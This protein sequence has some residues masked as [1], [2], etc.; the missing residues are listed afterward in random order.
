MV[1]YYFYKSIK[2]NEIKYW[3][4][5]G[6]LSGASF[7]GKYQVVILFAFM[8]L[9]LLIYDIKLLKQKRVY[10]AIL[11]GLLMILPHMIWLYKTDFFSLL[12][13]V[14]R[15][16]STLSEDDKF[17][18]FKRLMFSVK[19]YLD[20]LFSLAPTFALY[21]ILALKEK[22]ITFNGSI[23]ENLK[24]KLFLIIVGLMPVL[25]IGLSGIFTASRVV[26]AWAVSM[27]C[28]V[29]ILLF[30][31]FPIKFQ[32]K[33][34]IFFM[35]WIYGMMICW[36]IAMIIFFMLQTKKDFSYPYK[37]VM[38]DFNQIWYEKTE[39]APLKYV[40]GDYAISSHIYNKQKPV[41]ILDTYNHKNPWVNG[42]DILK[43]GVLILSSDENALPYLSD[44]FKNEYNIKNIS[45]IGEYSYT[46]SNIIGK[47]R[48]YNV[49]YAIIKPEKI[50]N[51]L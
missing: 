1:I 34:Y 22:N 44:K 30:Y 35:K 9:Y 5:F 14:N 4:I 29:G 16:A 3:L 43:S 47:S 48:T 12:Y 32:E 45:D 49:Y 42:D 31:F 10:G 2:F 7:L 27:I 21:G 37:K 46:I 6:I 19:F 25:T 18:F 51:G 33:T 28:C 11:T 24:D 23:K 40:A 36:Q 17:A 15:T 38:S 8:F 39:N 41:A 13:F 20:Q 26:G 50:I